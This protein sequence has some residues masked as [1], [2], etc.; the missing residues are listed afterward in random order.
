MFVSD[1]LRQDALRWL[2]AC[3]ATTYATIALSNRNMSQRL[4]WQLWSV[5]WREKAVL[6]GLSPSIRPLQLLPPAFW[7]RIAACPRNCG[8]NNPCPALFLFLLVWFCTLNS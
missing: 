7:M 1:Q 6:F 8:C 3:A 5:V 2:A 4:V